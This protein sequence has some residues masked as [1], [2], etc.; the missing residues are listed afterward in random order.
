VACAEP[1]VLT[2]HELGPVK[3]GSSL[4][5]LRVEKSLKPIF[6]ENENTPHG[7]CALVRFK[8]IPGATFIADGPEGTPTDSLRV[9]AV[10]VDRSIDTTLGI[11]VGSKASVTRKL[12]SDMAYQFKVHAE[13]GAKP[14][15]SGQAVLAFRLQGGK[16]S[17]VR[18]GLTPGPFYDEFTCGI[19]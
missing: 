19:W 1:L 13:P 16:V 14:A 17:E 15:P 12:R 3:F 11:H 7:K 6:L 4:R 9:M 18:G 10:K 8:T 5:S 2:P